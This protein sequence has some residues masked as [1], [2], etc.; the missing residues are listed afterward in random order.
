MKKII[1]A[2]N[3]QAKIK[4]FKAILNTFEVVPMGDMDIAE[5]PETGL[6]FAENALIKARNAAKHS[7]LPALAD[8]SGLNVE[9]LNG[10][11]GIYSARYSGGDDEQNIDKLLQNM[12]G[13]K[14]RNAYFYCAIV[15]LKYENDPTPIIAIGKWHGQIL[16]KRR[17]QN[18]FGYDSI[19]YL[20]EF[21]KSAAELGE[22]VKN[23][24]SHRALAVQDLCK[25][26]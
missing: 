20:P 25:K 13:I 3:N 6:T 26:L 1:L 8:D 4:E 19:F 12:T 22:A 18:G 7:G 16:Q 17:G 5:V 21:K 11:P 10:E 15:L 14:N 23:T 2:S 9:A 24:I